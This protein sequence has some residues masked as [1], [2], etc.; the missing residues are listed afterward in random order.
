MVNASFTPEGNV[1]TYVAGETGM[2]PIIYNTGDMAWILAAF[3]LVFSMA[4]GVGFLYSGLLRR[5]NALSMLFLSLMVFSLITVEWFLWGY[6][7]AFGEGSAFIG[8]LSHGGFVNV[9]IQ[10]SGSLPTLLFALYQGAFA[11]VTAVIAVGGAA[12]RARIVPLLVFI[13]CWSTIV[14]NSIAHWVWASSGWL[15]NLGDLDFAG[16]GPVHISSGTAG[17]ALSYFLGKRRGYGTSKLAFRPHSVSHVVIGT[18]FLWFGWFG[19]NGGSALG[20][21]LRTIQACVVTNVAA[22]TGGLTWVILDFIYTRKF[23]AVSLCSGILAG[24]IGITPGAGYVGTPAALAIGF[25]TAI[26]SNYATGIKVLLKIDDAVDTYA[27]HGVGGFVG[28]ILTA[29]FADDRVTSFD[30]VSSGAGWLNHN[31]IALGYNLAGAVTIMAY[32]FVMTLVLCYI[33]NW[34][35]GLEMRA[36]EDAEIMGMDEAECGEFAYD[37]LMIRKDMEENGLTTAAPSVHSQ[38]AS[39]KAPVTAA[40]TTV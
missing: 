23:S 10:P 19:F 27:L 14:Y 40:Q 33:I 28:A 7:L 38:D 20:M 16:G 3:C 31:Y 22:A 12:E 1:L 35:P 36:S 25:I 30:G 2:E 21:N 39:E 5:K 11:G 24:L 26:A 37:Y 32:T 8:D 29:L 15:F 34:I 13:F 6:S 18:L 9:D 4:P 17:F